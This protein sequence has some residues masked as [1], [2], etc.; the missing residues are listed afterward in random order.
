MKNKA[1]DYTTRVT[2]LAVLPNGGSLFSERATF[3]SVEDEGG[4]EFVVI[5]QQSDNDAI[6]RISLDGGPEWAAVKRAVER[7]LRDI[8]GNEKS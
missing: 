1:A 6:Q 2:R 8:T 4:G 3:V 5:E 7:L